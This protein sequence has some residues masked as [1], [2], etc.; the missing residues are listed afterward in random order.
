MCNHLS[1]FLCVADYDKLLPGWSHFA[2]FTIAVVN[3][4]PKKSK[5]SDT[6]HRFCKKEHD[7]GWKKFMEL[8]KVLDGF[9]VADTLVIKAQVQVIREN[10]TRPFRCLDAQY[11]REL[12]R[13]YLTNVEGIC[14]R[15]IEE[16][17]QALGHLCVDMQ[18][19]KYFWEELDAAEKS[20]LST[21]KADGVLRSVVKRFFN[22]KEV[23][24]TLV[25]D[26]LHSGCKALDPSNTGKLGC[27]FNEES[28]SPYIK[29]SPDDNQF[30]V[31]GD[32]LRILEAAAA[33]SLPRFNDEKDEKG[34][35][36]GKDS[37]ERDERRLAE[38]GRQTVEIFVISQIC[39]QKLE[40]AYREHAALKLQEDL[41][42]EEE[43]AERI[44]SER[45]AAKAAAEKA[46]KDK[47]KEKRQRQKERREQ[48][49]EEQR[50][51]EAEEARIR[52]EEE[53]RKA[54]ERA[55]REAEKAR[56]R[57]EQEE[58]KKQEERARREAERATR[59][60]EREKSR[61]AQA[62]AQA[63][64]TT[65]N[66][67]AKS[68]SPENQ[69]S[70][71]KTPQTKKTP[72]TSIQHGRHASIDGLPGELM[73][74]D[75]L[76]ASKKS[77]LVEH[78]RKLE[79]LLAQKESDLS[80]AYARLEEL[81][82]DVPQQQ[83]P[84]SSQGESK[85]GASPSRTRTT[86]KSGGASNLKQEAKQNGPQTHAAASNG[87][88]TSDSVTRQGLTSTMAPS[89]A[90]G[91]LDSRANPR[92]YGAIPLQ[93]GAPVVS[94]ARPQPGSSG[95]Q[96]ASQTQPLV[97]GRGNGTLHGQGMTSAHSAT[98]GSSPKPGNGM[99]AQQPRP[100]HHAF[101][102]YATGMVTGRGEAPG[103]PIAR[104][105]ERDSSAMGRTA[106]LQALRAHQEEQEMSSQGQST[107]MG[108]Q[109]KQVHP[110]P[111]VGES[112][113]LQEFPHLNLINDLLDFDA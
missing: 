73:G 98:A 64:K 106:G 111:Q 78:I 71:P 96:T 99:M 45:S 74:D 91:Q 65:K 97:P 69:G 10:L 1:L 17:R 38:L 56:Q 101:P 28:K 19:L 22:E 18:G 113:G 13:V 33:D 36:A 15:F 21:E 62:Q 112:P 94:Q 88:F 40:T 44:E 102:Q 57:A 5:Y 30:D 32:L 61:A 85:A 52:K 104:G 53:E 76:F 49:L 37:V 100:V 34:E 68:S 16:R 48:E 12:V 25:M 60:K 84:T 54:R 66:E 110:A 27:A 72:S 70:A 20:K 105:K 59:E 63:Q 51:R 4:D 39:I 93:R 7:W 26:A 43:E 35:E 89:A 41:I 14:F 86:E 108:S 81:G 23:T 80:V 2:Q 29:L 67:E 75:P 90:D 82:A 11:R 77:V 109:A 107:P 3:K 79:K 103:S 47:K 50:Q 9:T 42:R 95:L 87:N 6:L 92:P 55:E 83:V 31:N 8:S 58:K 46:K 24:S